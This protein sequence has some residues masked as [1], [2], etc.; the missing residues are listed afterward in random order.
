MQLEQ[1]EQG[2]EEKWRE[3]REKQIQGQGEGSGI[4]HYRRG[5]FILGALRSHFSKAIEGLQGGV[6]RDS[7]G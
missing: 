7:S 2:G 3:V 5:W 6:T 4:D 1:S